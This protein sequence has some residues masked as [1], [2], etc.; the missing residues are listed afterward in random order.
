MYLHLTN[1]LN[2]QGVAVESCNYSE[3]S[4][5]FQLSILA[6]GINCPHCKNYTEELHQVRPILVKD[7]PALGKDVYLNLPRRQFYCRVCQR[8][9]TERLEFIDWRRKYTQRYEKGIYL[10]VINSSIEQVS[11][12]E[13]LSIEQVKNI[14]N[15]VSHKLKKQMPL[16]SEK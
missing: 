1:L 9:I 13:R 11:Q 6:E 12:Q 10:Q 8:Y 4:V 7:L 14:Y 2:L 3:E 5:C 16:N 15:Y